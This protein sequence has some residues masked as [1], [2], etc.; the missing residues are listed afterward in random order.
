MVGLE[1]GWKERQS[2]EGVEIGAW[3]DEWERFGGRWVGGGLVPACP[4]CIAGPQHQS[5]EL[6][7]PLSW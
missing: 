3:G 6:P 5:R 7:F 2:P 4:A 1:E